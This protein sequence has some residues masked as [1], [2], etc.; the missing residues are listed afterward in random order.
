M[1]RLNL[2]PVLL[3]CW[4]LKSLT[5]C[6][7]SNFAFYG[8]GQLHLSHI[9][10]A[11]LQLQYTGNTYRTQATLP[12]LPASLL[13]H[14]VP[15]YHSVAAVASYLAGTGNQQRRELVLVPLLSPSTRRLFVDR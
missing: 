1:I 2:I 6:G 14:A 7:G 8:N 4:S 3:Y 15:D 9:G 13:R 12:R 10:E 11:Q 5:S